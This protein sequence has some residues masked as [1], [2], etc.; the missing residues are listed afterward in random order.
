MED[1]HIPFVNKHTFYRP[2]D[3]DWNVDPN[4]KISVRISF[5]DFDLLVYGF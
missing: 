3:N 1:R 5:L 4:M 2:G